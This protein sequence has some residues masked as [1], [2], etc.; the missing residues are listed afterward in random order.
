MTFPAADPLVS[1]PVYKIMPIHV[2]CLTISDVMLS[3]EV[4]GIKW[5]TLYR[6][7]IQAASAAP[8]V[9]RQHREDEC[10]R[11]V[12]CVGNLLV[13]VRRGGRSGGHMKTSA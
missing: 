8:G 7:P 13:N 3:N 10:H 5:G 2:F 11:A 4:G 12:I 1:I 6:A 9:V